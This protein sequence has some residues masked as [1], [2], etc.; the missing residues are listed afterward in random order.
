MVSAKAGS[1]RRQLHD[2]SAGGKISFKANEIADAREIQVTVYRTVIE[3]RSIVLERDEEGV[4][5]PDQC[6]LEMDGVGSFCLDVTNPVAGPPSGL[7]RAK[8][9]LHD[10]KN[11]ADYIET[12]DIQSKLIQIV[13]AVLSA[14]PANPW[15][16]NKNFMKN[17]LI[18][19]FW[20]QNDRNRV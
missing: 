7:S 8:S 1:T 10:H 16:L 9:I 11:A 12:N 19:Y 20:R 6:L 18:F 13:R 17:I 5:K 14:R 2:V 15:P 3:K 4:V